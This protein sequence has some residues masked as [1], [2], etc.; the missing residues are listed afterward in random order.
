MNLFKKINNKLLKI[1]E[2]E[3]YTKS[4]FD[5]INIRRNWYKYNGI[6]L[7]N[8]PYKKFNY[9]TIY[10]KNCENVIGF[11]QI[12]IGLVGPLKFHDKTYHIPIATTEGALVASINRGCV[13]IH[14]SNGINFIVDDVGMTR[15]P[16]IKFNNIYNTQF[17][18][19]YVQNNFNKLKEIFDS[20][21]KYGKLTKIDTYYAGEMLHVKFTATTGNAMGMNI[22]TKGTAKVIEY[23]K[24]IFP[25][26]ILISLSGN[27]C[28]D[29]KISSMN[30]IN[31]RGKRVVVENVIDNIVIKNVLKTTTHKLVELNNAKNYIGSALA[32]TI[33]GN[34]CNVSNI[35][36]GIFIAT[37]QDIGQVGT[38]SMSLVQLKEQN[39]NLHITVTL[40]CLEIGIIGGGTTLPS[41]KA[42]LDILN[43]NNSIEFAKVIAGTVMAGELSLLAALT[44]EN[45]LINA[46]L[47][48]NRK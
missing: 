15:A 47:T 11:T 14:Q 20:T 37:G 41:Q 40:P 32:G 4:K 48:L 25:E 7:D 26:M 44:N 24:I 16:I 23:L 29:K 27:M 19:N 46:H 17:F 30:L 13:A 36:A 34:N 45:E 2:L 28:T 38:S 1:Y 5:A 33:G 10:R 9:D 3:K 39:N 43:I 21:T 22:L 35:I 12:P 31:G 42:G 18:N 6:K 8:I